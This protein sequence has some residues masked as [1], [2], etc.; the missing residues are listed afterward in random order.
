[1]CTLSIRRVTTTDNATAPAMVPST[2]PTNAPLL[3]P[4]FE[5]VEIPVTLVKIISIKN[6]KLSNSIHLIHIYERK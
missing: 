3:T 1:M 4:D 5:E 6:S 2:M